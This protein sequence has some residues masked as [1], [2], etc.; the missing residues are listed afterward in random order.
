M[1]HHHHNS[2]NKQRATMSVGLEV[3]P[4]GVPTVTVF[5]SKLVYTNV[6]FKSHWG[7]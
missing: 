2:L 7:P 6:W 5:I 4:L 1:L 3:P